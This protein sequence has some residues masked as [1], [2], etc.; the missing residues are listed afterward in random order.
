MG[1]RRHH[2]S[3]D[4]GEAFGEHNSWRHAP[5]GLA[6][7][8]RPAFMRIPGRRPRAIDAPRGRH[9]CPLPPSSSS[10]REERAADDRQ[11]LMP[12]IGG[13]KPECA[14]SSLSIRRGIDCN[15]K[16]RAMIHEE[17]A[18]SRKSR[19]REIR[20][21]LRPRVRSGRGDSD[22]LG[23]APASHGARDARA[24]PERQ[25]ARSRSRCRA[26]VRRA[27][28]GRRGGIP[29]GVPEWS[30]SRL[31]KQWNGMERVWRE[32]LEEGWNGNNGQGIT[33]L[34]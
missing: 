30:L 6:A 7:R 11:E 29:Q 26:V 33:F 20:L 31:S 18:P 27:R 8:P 34:K 12:E 21:R 32:H 14:T 28:H 9:R 5:R 22:P 19:V 16:R 23:R 24:L 10:G 3:A 4:H 17:R 1:R 2:V 25:H 13:A 15:E